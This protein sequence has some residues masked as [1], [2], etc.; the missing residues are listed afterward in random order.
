MN[1][2]DFLMRQYGEEKV[3]REDS[4]IIRDSFW[5]SVRSTLFKKIHNRE[6]GQLQWLYIIGKRSRDSTGRKIV[7]NSW[8]VD[9]LEK[10][11][12][13]LN[14]LEGLEE[15]YKHQNYEVPEHID[16]LINKI[17]N[18]DTDRTIKRRFFR[19][20]MKHRFDIGEKFSERY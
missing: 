8:T 3:D 16:D 17:R 1:Y 2:G 4:N 20:L 15:V 12:K 19:L 11:V 9:C 14:S 10:M 7:L 6:G 18:S 5:S 13:Y